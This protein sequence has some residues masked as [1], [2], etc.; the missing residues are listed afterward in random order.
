MIKRTI[1][2]LTIP[3][4]KDIKDK[5]DK[6][7]PKNLPSPNLYRI[8]AKNEPLFNDLIESKFIGKTGVF[9]RKRLA[10]ELRE[11]IILRTCVA[12]NNEY[13][14]NLHADTISEKMG[15]S[16]KQIADLR[17][18]NL[19]PDYWNKE[20]LALF[21]MIDSLVK[22]IKVSD[23]IFDNVSQYYNESLLVEIIHIIGF[24]TGVAMLVAFS[25][26]EFDNYKNPK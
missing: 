17:N 13:E 8:V 15:L 14:F 2:P 20:D 9:D 16:I 25:K 26:P 1:E 21:D 4:S 22:Q 10:P 23:S 3:L 12:T 6:I 11:K 5:M 24:Y 7:F 18:P 19:N